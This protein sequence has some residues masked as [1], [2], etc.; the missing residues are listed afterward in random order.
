MK[1]Y[2]VGGAVRDIAMGLEPK[3]RDYVVV[4]E[5]VEAMLARGFRQVGKDFPVFHHPETGDEYALAR[6]ERKC[7]AGHTGFTVSTRGVSLE[8][9][10]SRRD[11]TI[12]SMAMDADGRIVDPYQGQRDLKERVFRH[13]SAA[14]SEDPLRILRI[15]RFLARLGPQWSVAPETLDL[16]EQMLSQN[17][18]DELPFERFWKELE[19]GLMEPYP[20]LMFGFMH[21]YQLFSRVEKLRP[22]EARPQAEAEPLLRLA[23]A[24]G[25]SAAVRFAV[26]CNCRADE[27]ERPQALPVEFWHIARA[28]QTVDALPVRKFSSATANEKLRVVQA[29]DAIRRP[30]RCAEVLAALQLAGAFDEEGIHRAILALKAID[31]QALAAG[32]K[33]GAEVGA[34]L[35][36]ERHRVL[37]VLFA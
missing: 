23:A 22:L 31:N 37:E 35:E 33:T 19:R 9:D 6:V 8:E 2:L 14:F 20:E 36:L 17:A 12:N 11:L 32:C 7:G 24:A 30:G 27:R 26:A 21:E 1:T 13:T 28:A 16:I 5:T 34:R 15:A 25:Q 3:D 29:L 10:L 18:L 4:G